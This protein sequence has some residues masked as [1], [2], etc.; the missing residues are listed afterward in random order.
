MSGYTIVCRNVLIVLLIA[1]IDVD[2]KGSHI[3]FMILLYSLSGKKVKEVPVV[4]S[5]RSRSADAIDAFDRSMLRYAPPRLMHYVSESRV[6]SHLFH[7]LL[8][9]VVLSF[10]AYS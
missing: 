1:M 2:R 5:C 10:I 9:P 6:L 3:K 4:V 7:R 8:V